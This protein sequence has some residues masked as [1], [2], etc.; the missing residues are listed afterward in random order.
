MTAE[1]IVDALKGALPDLQIEIVPS[2]DQPTL[3]VPREQIV[4]VCTALRDTPAL[5][6]ACLDLTA[7]DWWPGEPRFQ[8]VYHL[9]SF[10]ESWSEGRDV[11][12]AEARNL[13]PIAQRLRLKVPLPGE[14]AHVAT[15]SALCPGANWLEREVFDLFGIIFDG[16]PDLRRVLMPEDWEGYPLRKDYPVQ[17]E[18][19]VKI[20]ESLG[21]TTE[22]FKENIEADRKARG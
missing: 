14:D 17:I 20:H 13:R 19:P 3:V 11:S 6:F 12:R 7:V 16:H 1:E 15:I 22:E 4:A 10:G 2:I 8:V 18:L 21:M 5:R 9:A